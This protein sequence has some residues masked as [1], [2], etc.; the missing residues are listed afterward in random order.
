MIDGAT[1]IAWGFKPGRWFKQGLETAN[2]MR[3]AG[4]SDDAIFAQLQTLV[5]PE[6][7]M[8]TN[9]L[10]Y[11][12]FLDT[13]TPAERANAASVAA[14]MDALM[15]VPTI[16]AGAVMPDAC[17]SGTQPGTIPVGGVVACE[18]AIHPGF[19]SADICCSVAVTVFK[20]DDDPA[21]VLDAVQRVTHFGPGGRDTPIRP[22]FEGE[23]AF[24]DNPFLKGLENMA[25]GHFGSQGDGNHFAFVGRLKS[26]GR[27]ALV[28]HHGSRGL[29][30]QLYKR[31][32][33]AARRHTG[34]VAPR[35]PAHNAWIKADSPD[36]EAYWQALQIVRNWTKANHGIIHA[37]VRQEIGNQVL[38]A[39]WN[40]HNFVFR[41]DDGLF[42]HGKGAT[43]SWSGYA[44]DDDGRTLIPLNMSEPILIARHRD[45]G[46]S[47]GFAPHGAGR[48]ASRTQ[49]LRENGVALAAELAALQARGLDIRSYCGVPDHS[50]LPS[51]YKNAASVRAQIAKYH[52]AEIV[53]E[54]E[55]C[56]S[57]MAGDWEHDAPWRK[58]R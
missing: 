43:P 4:E 6:T 31:G 9:G 58:A 47:L 46:G 10:P 38:D 15:R 7:L 34:I 35:V 18:D 11:G 36:G 14:H 51:A 16:K 17:P 29:G 5:P 23:A 1:L 21:K 20:R 56:G 8:R 27:I 25:L 39:F 28:T 45:H 40:E 52:L 26:S 53:D 55:P 49:H 33:A 57:I 30:A 12:L 54:I 32:M 42:Y 41:R 13:E 2:A 22:V 44:A 3:A 50:E 19:H 24:S 37:M 48:N